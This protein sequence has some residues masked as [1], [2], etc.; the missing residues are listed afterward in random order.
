MRDEAVA[1]PSGAQAV[2]S[3]TE[4]IA[5]IAPPSQPPTLNSISRAYRHWS[6]IFSEAALQCRVINGF[7]AALAAA[8]V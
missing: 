6:F 5:S 8:S 4:R 7:I 3:D 1:I 2:P